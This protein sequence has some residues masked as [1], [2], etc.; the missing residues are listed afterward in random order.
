MPCRFL[1]NPRENTGKLGNKW[2]M[3]AAKLRKIARWG[4]RSLDETQKKLYYL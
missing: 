1:N 3:R 4:M 2:G